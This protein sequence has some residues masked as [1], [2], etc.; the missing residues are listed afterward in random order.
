[1]GMRISYDIK[2]GD[3][4]NQEI[5]IRQMMSDNGLEDARGAYTNQYDPEVVVVKLLDGST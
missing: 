3:D 1:M 5:S 4:I 2:I